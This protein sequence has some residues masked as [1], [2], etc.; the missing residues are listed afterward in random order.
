MAW[1]LTM[2]PTSTLT[3]RATIVIL[4]TL[5]RR[6]GGTMR[7][8]TRSRTLTLQCIVEIDAVPENHALVTTPWLPRS[9][10]Q[11]QCWS[12]DGFGALESRKFGQMVDH[13]GK[14]VA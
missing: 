2:D 8:L 3:M 13:L 12:Q 14:L 6:L 5:C 11:G 1:P 4:R 9:G 10:Y 7:K